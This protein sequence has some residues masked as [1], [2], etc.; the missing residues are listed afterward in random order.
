MQLLPDFA[1]KCALVILLAMCAGLSLSL[2]HAQDGAA[3]PPQYR[4]TVR[5]ALSEYHAKNFP[6]AR[7]LFTEAHALY[8]NARTLRGLGM[9]A[10]ELRSYHESITYLKEA[11]A[12][13]V[14]PLDGGL[15]GETERLLARAERFV[16]TLNLTV[17]PEGASVLVDGNQVARSSWGE[18][19]AEPLMLEVGEHALEFQAEGYHSEVRSLHVKGR[20]TETWR[21]V[22]NPLP[23]AQAAPV[24]PPP[25][26][27][28]EPAEVARRSEPSTAPRFVSLSPAE[29]SDKRPL[30]K[31]PWL[32][33]GVGAVV[34]AAVIVGVVVATHKSEVGK[35]Q[36]GDNTPP[37]GVFSALEGAR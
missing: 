34:V 28:P 20:E 27:V 32:W 31:N 8:P 12:S 1:R 36:V 25:A 26:V 15:R 37:G 6:E 13:K 18:S 5:E 3:E 35:V 2:A 14:K 11:L 4:A 22:L 24:P 33:T 29:M 23:V 19:N 17:S 30:Y 9:T 10:F 7:A 21:V 16:G